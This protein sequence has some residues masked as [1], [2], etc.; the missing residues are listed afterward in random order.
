MEADSPSIHAPMISLLC[1]AF[2]VA[3]SVS[4][5]LGCSA[6]GGAAVASMVM[7]LVAGLIARW[8]FQHTVSQPNHSR[9]LQWDLLQRNHGLLQSLMDNA[10]V[11]MALKARDGHTVIGK[12]DIE[13]TLGL[14]LGELTSTLG[15]RD[16]SDHG[17]WTQPGNMRPVMESG[18]PMTRLVSH[19]GSGGL[20]HMEVTEFPL[21]DAGR[22]FLGVGLMAVDVTNREITNEK[23]VRVF[24]VSPN[25]I[26]ITRLSDGVVIDANEGFEILSG[27]SR[28]AVVGRPI[29]ELNIWANP[30]QR[31]AIVETLL[32][33]GRVE[34]GEA[35]MRLK[36]GRLRDFVTN[37]VLI[38]LEGQSNSH[39]VW[40]ARD[41]TDARMAE[42]ALRDSEAR[43]VTLFEMSP[44]PTSYSFDTDG[45]TTSYRNAAFY[46]TFGYS[47]ETDRAKSSLEL[48]FWAHPEDAA[49][50]QRY[51]LN[52]EPVDNWVVEIRHA[53]GQSLWVSIFARFIVEPH[54]KILVTTMF[55]ITEQ[56]RNQLKIEELNAYLE[57]RVSER[58]QQL[59]TSNTEL[60]QALQTLEQARDQLVQAEKLASLGALVAGI[61]HELNTPIGNGLTVASALQE[62]AKEFATLAKQ[63]MQRSS[64]DTFIGETHMAA[65]LLVRSLSRSAALISSFKQVAVDQASSQRRH[66]MLSHLVDEVTLTMS[67]ATRRARC[68]VI[69][70]IEPNL[71][72]DSYPGPVVQVLTNLLN[73]AMIHGFEVGQPGRVTISG[74]A[75][76]DDEVEIRVQD[77]GKGIAPAHI[78]RIF[79]PFF[80]TRLGQG[81]SGLGLHVVHNIVTR[82]L[83]GRI[84]VHSSLGEGAEFV[85]QIPRVAPDQ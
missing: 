42:K 45:F 52:G 43:F 65:D 6:L 29:G 23:F 84:E 81:G 2:T 35:Q 31:A 58:T 69:A 85:L 17:E 16:T 76:G 30:S 38:S 64:L 44:V 8:A 27:H 26:V 39:A 24:H 74:Q 5:A 56:R 22:E 60:S 33:D 57:D 77:N 11:V 9:Q 18:Q 78:K 47:P 80:T 53:S 55:D 7:G 41:V 73:N 46:A 70:Q 63:P 19:Q 1:W 10:P 83:G 54:R 68:E 25:W 21:F 79:D 4:I 34:D 62:K 36:D 50:A 49:Q 20:R 15:L 71:S 66:F 14:S 75:L 37:A 3:T 48:G 40:I 72:L 13:K 32:R 12:T 67:P 59:Q 28:V 82:V 61:A 51:R